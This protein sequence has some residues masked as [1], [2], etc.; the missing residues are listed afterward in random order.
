MEIPRTISALPKGTAF[1]RYAMALAVAKGSLPDAA[2]YAKQWR[3]SPQV[4]E[5]L[6]A[7][8]AVGSTDVSAW[9]KPLSIYDQMAG[10]FIDALRPATIIGRI[11]GLARAP[12]NVR[13]ARATSGTSA[14]WV[15]QSAPKPI[16]KMSLDSITLQPL[17][18]VATC[19]LSDELVRFSSP[20]AV[21]TVQRDLIA[22]LAARLDSAFIDPTLSA[23][24]NVS[25]ASITSGISATSSTG[26]SV[27]QIVTDVKAALAAGIAAGITWQTGVWVMHPRTALYLSGVLTAGNVPMWPTIS[28]KG[29]T[30]YGLP[31]ITS[32]S[33]PIDTGADTYIALLDAANILLAEGTVTLD[34][35]TQASLQMVTN[36]SASATETVSLWQ[37]NLVGIRS[38]MYA[39]WARKHDAAVAVIDDVAF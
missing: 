8:V 11:G 6:R 3:D 38:E 1:M 4:A 29:G 19:V 26:S 33:V 23:V 39:N 36:P 21:A 27:A 15:G 24:T 34:I 18:V 14:D 28:V 25:P 12:F 30:W 9:A 31:V 2:E 37:S 20:P 32:S 22:A 7:A 10:E 17:K 13:M 35:S 16:S 5:V